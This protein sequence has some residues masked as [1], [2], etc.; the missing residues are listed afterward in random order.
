[1][2]KIIKRI[3]VEGAQNEFNPTVE[4]IS[5]LKYLYI[6]SSPLARL[7][8]RYS[9]HPNTITTISNVSIVISLYFLYVGNFILFILLWIVAGILDICD[10]TVARLT[11][12][13]SESGAF[14]DHFSD[15][16]K[17]FLFFISISLYF[18]NELITYL[19]FVSAGIFFLYIDISKR[20]VIFQLKYPNKNEHI[21]TENNSI[22]F[23]RKIYNNIFLI[24]GHTMVI[25][26]FFVINKDMAIIGLSLFILVASKNFLSSLRVKI[27]LLQNKIK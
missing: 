23:F 9:V 27:R 3:Y 21:N 20:V 18:Q 14:Y 17:M 22:K 11:N 8:A 24:H 12:K 26:P 5:L 2:R 4:K 6:I 15:Q 10:G 1:M 13:T 16:V 25:L 7:F 19:A